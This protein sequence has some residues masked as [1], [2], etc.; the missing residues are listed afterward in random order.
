MPF[1]NISGRLGRCNTR[2]FRLT[3][4]ASNLGLA[5][6]GH[7]KKLPLTVWAGANQSVRTDC[8]CHPVG[9]SQLRNLLRIKEYPIWVTIFP[10]Y[11]RT[12]RENPYEICGNGVNLKL[13][14][15][16]ALDGLCSEVQGR[17]SGRSLRRTIS[18]I[19]GPEAPPRLVSARRAFPRRRLSAPHHRLVLQ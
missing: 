8:H 2:S 9:G 14:A 16:F 17:T 11:V 10:S 13:P 5:G 3:M 19:C 4:S 18:C 1:A 15:G 6:I 7:D 12:M